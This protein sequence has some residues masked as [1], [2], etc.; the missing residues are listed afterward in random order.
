[1]EKTQSTF[2]GVNDYS[3]IDLKNWKRF[4]K[5][6]VHF[7]PTDEQIFVPMSDG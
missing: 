5:E 1:M 7:S 2:T 6:M 4:S 3:Q